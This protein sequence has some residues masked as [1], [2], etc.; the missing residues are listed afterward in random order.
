M[1]DLGY[2]HKQLLCA[3]EVEC[4]VM[5]TIAEKAED[6]QTFDWHPIT[7][8]FIRINRLAEEKYLNKMEG[9]GMQ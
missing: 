4:I 8:A 9:E 1:S 5:D 3:S 6:F 2:R 7:E